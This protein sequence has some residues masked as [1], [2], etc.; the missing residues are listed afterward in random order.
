VTLT[1][2]DVAD[3]VKII[4]ASNCDELIVEIAGAKIV[5]RRSSG[6]VGEA[7]VEPARISTPAQVEPL[8]ASPL[9]AK[10]AANVTRP[11]AP[12]ERGTAAGGKAVVRSPMVGTFYRAP[13][14]TDP[15]FVDVGSTVQLGDPL[16][17]IEVMKL[18]TTI[19]AERSGRITAILPENAQLVEFDQPL[20]EMEH[21]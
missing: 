10:P 11:A 12:L 5:V 20:F 6:R 19:S 13:S 14:P 18:F 1:L 15:P 21:G 16:C 9:Q 2:K 7:A 8:A 3:I 17:V 4:D